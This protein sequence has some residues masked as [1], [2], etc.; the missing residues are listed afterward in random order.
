[1]G[2]TRAG[3]SGA[4][5]GR[6]LPPE[7]SVP[8]V[9]LPGVVTREPTAQA[10][11]RGGERVRVE[12]R[13]QLGADAGATAVETAQRAQV[14]TPPGVLTAMP[15]SAG[16]ATAARPAPGAARARVV[17][18]GEAAAQKELPGLL[19]T[20]ASCVT[21]PPLSRRQCRVAGAAAPAATVGGPETKNAPPMWRTG[22]LGGAVAR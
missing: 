8:L 17:R 14:A 1:M 22:P 19:R 21:L 18:P 13:L 7:K 11:V 4:G 20:A 5:R 16:G 2:A 3:K 6:V 9:P 12:L 10:H 15:A